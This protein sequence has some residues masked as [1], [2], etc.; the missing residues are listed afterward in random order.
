MMINSKL[1]HILKIVTK[2]FLVGLLLQFFLQTFVTYK[3][4]LDGI[5]RKIVRMRK[6]IVLIGLFGLL[7]YI[8]QKNKL[9]KS[10][11]GKLPIKRFIILFLIL[12]GGIGLISLFITDV[13]ISAYIM[14]IR[15]SMIGFFIFILFFVLKF[16]EQ[17]EQEMD[18]VKRYSD[19]IKK[20]LMGALIRW[21]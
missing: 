8:I 2:I 10:L 21:G 20:I 7:A 1:P 12:I 18:M 9:W 14:S 6:E 15:Y 17:G 4:G 11:R 13:G 16:I 19:I 3:L 5:F